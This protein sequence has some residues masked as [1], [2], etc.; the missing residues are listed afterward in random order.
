MLR[1][2]SFSTTSLTAHFRHHFTILSQKFV[3]NAKNQ[4]HFLTCTQSNVPNVKMMKYSMLKI[5]YAKLNLIT[6]T[7]QELKIGISMEP[8]YLKLT[9]VWLL[10]QM[11]NLTL[12]ESFVC[13]AMFLHIGVCHQIYARTVK[14]DLPLMPIH[15]NAR[16]F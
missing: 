9:K 3:S 7:S 12:M 1:G 14:V 5:K 15:S 2:L 4:P 16:K 10:V 11:I 6:Q 13:L 8:L